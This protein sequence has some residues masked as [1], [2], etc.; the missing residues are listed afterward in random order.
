[1]AKKKR[2]RAKVGKRRVFSKDS[3]FTRL[4]AEVNQGSV[5]RQNLIA[6]LEAKYDARVL[7]FFTSFTNPRGMISDVDPEMIESILSVEQD[8]ARL[9]LVVNS[10]GGQGLA[11]ERIVNVCR[12]YSGNRFSVLVPHMAKS[13]ATLI[14]FG[15]DEI[16]MSRTAELGPVDPQ[17]VYGDEKSAMQISAAEYVRS[18]EQLVSEASSGKNQRIEPFLQQLN[19]FDARLIQQLKSAQDLARDISVRHLQASM[20]KGKTPADIEKA[21]NVF[22]AQ[23]ASKDHGRM[24]TFSEAQSC[25]LNVSEIDLR[26]PE[27]NTAWELYVRSNWVVGS[28]NRAAKLLES[29]RSSVTA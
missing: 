28:G 11:A 29:R 6:K 1:M 25:G 3:P 5:M 20:M 26:S 17:F 15:A 14:C 23:S 12:S 9:I 21:I 8:K 24:I 4:R 13:A 2:I 18:Y 16:I 27:W 22:L 19:R 10:P 7:T